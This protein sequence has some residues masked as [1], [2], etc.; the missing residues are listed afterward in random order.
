MHR[1]VLQFAVRVAAAE[2]LALARKRMLTNPIRIVLILA[3]TATAVLLLSRGE[4]G[5]GALFL[6]AGTLQV[7]SYFRN[8]TLWLAVRAYQQGDPKAAELLLCQIQYPELLQKRAQPQF[9]F[10]KGITTFSHGELAKAEPHLLQAL[11]AVASLS[12]GSAC[13]VHCMLA[14][15]EGSRGNHSGARQHLEAAR[16][17][18]HPAA[19]DQLIAETEQRMGAAA[20]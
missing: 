17:N 5:I 10:L 13:M 16:S 3:I 20:G 18:P 11:S 4:W 2:R 15:V 1:N 12:P 7:I 9:H 8:G 14:S 19:L 6:V